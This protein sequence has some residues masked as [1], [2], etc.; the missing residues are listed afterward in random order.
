M[1]L[2]ITGTRN[3]FTNPQFNAFKTLLQSLLQENDVEK[4]LQGQCQGVDVQAADVVHKVS[5][6]VVKI[7]S[8][9]PIKK[10]LIGTCHVDINLPPKNYLARDRDIADSSDILFVCPAHEEPQDTGG[11]WYT[12]KYAL[13]KGKK[14]ILI[15]PSGI[16]T[17][18]NFE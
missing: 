10:H 9:P 17:K 5:R 13:S 11:T 6:G 1:I 15:T 7:Q 14:I 18:I 8:H 12:Y 16:I 4:F 2:G 3:G